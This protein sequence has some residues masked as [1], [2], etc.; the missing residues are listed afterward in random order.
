MVNGR[1]A[2]LRRC[3]DGKRPYASLAEAKAAAWGMAE[4]KL[5]KGEP[6]VTYLR[7]YGCPCGRF[8]I[9][10]TRD[11]NWDLVRMVDEN[12]KRVARGA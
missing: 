3:H 7:A 11:I 12:I 5:K 8:H 1:A 6:I 9:G 2:R 4:R 10:K